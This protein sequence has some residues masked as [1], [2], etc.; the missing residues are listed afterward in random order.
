[1]KLKLT[2]VLAALLMAGIPAYAAHQPQHAVQSG[3]AMSDG[4]VRK[5]DKAAGKV[6]I[7]HG[8]LENLGMP[9][10]TMVFRVQ[11]PALLDQVQVGDKVSFVAEKIGGQYTVTKIERRN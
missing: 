5:I 7:K 1:M 6:T 4:E 11:D 2:Y 9:P 3:A 10:M 8:P